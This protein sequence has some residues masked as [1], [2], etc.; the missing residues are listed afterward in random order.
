MHAM[1]P[2][3]DAA[4]GPSDPLTVAR[5][6]ARLAGALALLVAGGCAP[7]PTPP[8]APIA[9]PVETRDA[10]AASEAGPVT[11]IAALESGLSE[12]GIA[13]RFDAE[14]ELDYLPGLARVYQIG[15]GSDSLQVHA[16]PNLSE[17]E[18]AA[19][20]IGPDARWIDDPK[21]PGNPW[22]VDWKGRPQ[23]YRSG[24]LLAIYIGQDARIETALKALLGPP[25]AGAKAAP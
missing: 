17:A 8:A 20:L 23:A 10:A 25:F 6:R 18:A 1:D 12:S 15:P 19:A 7:A 11:E 2:Q 22:Y 5:R 24:P 4:L 13:F 16:Y 3:P 9:P 14:T 21:D